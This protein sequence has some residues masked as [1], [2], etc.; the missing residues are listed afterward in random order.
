MGPREILAE[1]EKLGAT[2]YALAIFKALHTAMQSRRRRKGGAHRELRHLLAIDPSG[3]AGAVLKNIMADLGLLESR[4][5]R[6]AA[7]MWFAPEDVDKGE[8]L[9]EFSQAIVCVDGLDLDGRL[10]AELVEKAGEAKLVLAVFRSGVPRHQA[11]TAS[12]LAQQFTIYQAGDGE[13]S[14]PE[15]VEWDARGVA[16]AICVEQ[17]AS[18]VMTARMAEIAEAW[19]EKKKGVD[20]ET[21]S[22]GQARDYV[23]WFVF[24]R[25]VFGDTRDLFDL[26]RNC[27]DRTVIVSPDVLVE[28]QPA[29]PPTADK[30]QAQ[31][32]GEGETPSGIEMRRFPRIVVQVRRV[33]MAFGPLQVYF[34]MATNMSVG[35][36]C[37]WLSAPLA[38]DTVVAVRIGL[39]DEKPPFECLAKVVWVREGGKVNG[40]QYVTGIEFTG[41]TEALR[42][43]LEWY[44]AN[45]VDQLH[46][47]GEP[48]GPAT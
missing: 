37:V 23:D 29:E 9:T 18:E 16:K 42:H 7:A 32:E 17:A 4:G 33:E 2:V 28:Q 15:P 14:P 48:T 30:G 20:P 46:P 6:S 45:F 36:A 24:I 41:R 47:E 8:G 44:L 21:V 39:P 10:L 11:E 3:R 5:G 31:T 35:G 12:F 38:V 34:G 40:F 19:S 25:S 22:S 26:A 43:R 27:A 1:I 13:M